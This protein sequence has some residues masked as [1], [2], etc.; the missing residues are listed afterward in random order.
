MQ[1]KDICPA[2]GKIYALR[3]VT[4]TVNSLP[5]ICGSILSKKIAEGINTLVLDIKTG[6]GAFMKKYE[7]AL[8]LGDLMKNIG[9]EFGLDVIPTFTG[10][11]QPLGQSAGIWCEI[12]ESYEFLKGNFSDDLYK[13]VLH[14]FQKFNPKKNTKAI[15]DDIISSGNGLNK[16]IEFVEIQGGNF[17]KIE[18]KSVNNPSFSKESYTHKIG[19]VRSMDTRIIGFALSRLGAGRS[20]KS[21]KIDSTC[22]VDFFKKIGDKVS[23]E[24]PLFKIYGCNEQKLLN[25]EKEIRSA[26]EI[27]S[28]STG[29]YNPIISN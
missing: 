17:S 26:Y 3:D 20:Q 11:D 16:F 18:S 1:T 15:F 12:L 6:N 2:D 19:Y 27:V 9:N 7:D 21:R 5:L 24:S 10:M 8:K 14:L 13:V 4:A 23:I 29:V 25:A 28:N 22:G